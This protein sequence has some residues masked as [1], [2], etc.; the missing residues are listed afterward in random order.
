MF[1]LHRTALRSVTNCISDRV[2]VHTWNEYLSTI[3]ISDSSS[4]ATIL[5]DMWRND[6]IQFTEFNAIIL[7]WTQHRINTE[8]LY[9]LTREKNMDTEED[10]LVANM[11]SNIRLVNMVN[12]FTGHSPTFKWTLSTGNYYK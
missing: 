4:D 3:F 10:I 6:S 2:F 7:M 11:V 9:F 12:V 5:C 1:T 8:K